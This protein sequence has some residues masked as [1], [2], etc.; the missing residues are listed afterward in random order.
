ML[1]ETD[2]L[3]QVI[4]Y[5]KSRSEC[6]DFRQLILAQTLRPGQ[7]YMSHFIFLPFRGY[8]QGRI[9]GRSFET[10]RLPR[11]PVNIDSEVTAALLITFDHND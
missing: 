4:L 5:K 2:W 8:R 7:S 6:Y 3:R 9:G 1:P 10:Y 11:S